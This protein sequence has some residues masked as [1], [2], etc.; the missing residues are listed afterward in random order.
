[1][2]IGIAFD[3]KSDHAGKVEG[4]DDRL[5]EYDTTATVE[6][7]AEAL[8][9]AGHAPRALGGGRGDAAAWWFSQSSRWPLQAFPRGPRAPSNSSNW[10]QVEANGN[11]SIPRS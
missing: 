8:R 4:P 3:L 7:I 2:D 6:A 1:M 11:S 9:A 10:S 5:E